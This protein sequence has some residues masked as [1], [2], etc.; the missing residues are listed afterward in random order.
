MELY[1]V[2]G[3][4]NKVR[5]ANAI[6]GFEILNIALG[7]DEIQA[8]ETRDVVED[9]ARRAYDELKKSKTS[10]FAVI[11]E[12]TGLHIES[13]NRYPGAFIKWLLDAVGVEGICTKMSQYSGRS[14]TAETCVCYYDGNET[15]IFNGKVN[16]IITGSPRGETN[17]G[18]DPIFQPDRFQKTF[19]EMGADEKNS[20]SHRKQAFLGLK[21]YLDSK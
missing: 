14:A 21:S 3:N 1:F 7:I 16:G 11:V 8:I 20:I 18:W 19:A 5:E 15:R 4:E 13:W 10:D 6:L 17:F 12:D 9:K 2:T